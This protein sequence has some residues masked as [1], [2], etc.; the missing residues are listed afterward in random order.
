MAIRAFITLG[1]PVCLLTRH[2]TIN[3]ASDSASSSS[4]SNPCHVN[5]LT[6]IDTAL[7]SQMLSFHDLAD[8]DANTL[9]AQNGAAYSISPLA[10]TFHR[11]TESPPGLGI[12][13]TDI[14]S[15]LTL[16]LLRV[17]KQQHTNA[18][19]IRLAGNS[20][21]HPPSPTDSS[22]TLAA[23]SSFTNLFAPL[24]PSLTSLIQAEKGSLHPSKNTLPSSISSALKPQN[25]S[26]MAIDATLD[27][28][29]SLY[30]PSSSL[31]DTTY[32]PSPHLLDD[33]SRSRLL[34][35]TNNDPAKALARLHFLSD[36]G[37]VYDSIDELSDGL[38]R[39]G[40]VL[41][42]YQ[43]RLVLC[44]TKPSAWLHAT[45]TVSD[46]INSAT[47]STSF[48][49]DASSHAR[50]N[51]QNRAVPHPLSDSDAEQLCR[52]LGCAFPRTAQFWRLLP[53]PKDP[54]QPVL[55]DAQLDSY[56][57]VYTFSA[58]QYIALYSPSPP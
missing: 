26:Q 51:H 38:L 20:S 15:S 37:F 42:S 29:S 46:D 33:I 14:S 9:Y 31:G 12:P 50:R 3:D 36:S 2:A 18:E 57:D 41:D 6:S 7:D 55:S 1:T 52:S 4:P 34:P 53:P 54:T 11:P 22:G 58:F 43:S 5:I 19:T 39:L 47:S 10:N 27:N 49:H 23:S 32:T 24:P 40:T 25:L 8:I 17:L 35:L 56:V 13:L 30:D 16:R 44:F 48:R 21:T 28:H 45:R